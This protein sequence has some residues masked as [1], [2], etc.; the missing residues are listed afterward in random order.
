MTEKRVNISSSIKRQLNGVKPKTTNIDTQ[1]SSVLEH[2]EAD[3]MYNPD[4]YVTVNIM[5]I[6]V[7]VPIGDNNAK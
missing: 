2:L 3:M 7:I 1:D 6:D 4:K 5:G